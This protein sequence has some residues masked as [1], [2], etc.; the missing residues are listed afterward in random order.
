MGC[1]E[2]YYKRAL[3]KL[4]YNLT[5]NEDR[6]KAIKI[7][8]EN[9]ED[10]LEKEVIKLKNKTVDIQFYYEAGKA[11]QSIL[12]DTLKND[13]NDGFNACIGGLIEFNIFIGIEE[14]DT[15]D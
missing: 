1:P 10:V 3:Q 12:E 14:R 8:E 4:I 7:L 11:F 6:E 13:G 5:Y 9:N 15:E 2:K